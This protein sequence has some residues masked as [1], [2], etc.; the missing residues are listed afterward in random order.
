[1]AAKIA[2]EENATKIIPTGGDPQKVLDKE[3]LIILSMSFLV[4][5]QLL[6]T[7]AEA[8]GKILQ[9]LEVEEEKLILEKEAVDTTTN[10]RNVLK[11]VQDEVL[12]KQVV[13]EEAKIIF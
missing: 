5:F 2:K 8:M 12:V 3:N 11:L 1:M 7:E 13:L 6:I 9:E 10:A 4:S